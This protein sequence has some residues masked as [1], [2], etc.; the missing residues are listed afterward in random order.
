VAPLVAPGKSNHGTGYA[1]DIGGNNN[2]TTQICKAWGASLVF[3][4][5]SHV[6]VEWKNGVKIPK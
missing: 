1:L 3:N 6:H 2:K 4:E 5:A